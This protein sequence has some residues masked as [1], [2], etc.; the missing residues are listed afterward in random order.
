[1]KEKSH[2]TVVFLSDD[3]SHEVTYYCSNKKVPVDERDHSTQLF[4]QLH[5]CICIL[6]IDKKICNDPQSLETLVHNKEINTKAHLC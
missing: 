6:T 5:D 4:I 1:M 3:S 2:N